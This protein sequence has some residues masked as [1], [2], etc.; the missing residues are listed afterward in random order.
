MK[1]Y[2]LKDDV[3]NDIDFPKGTIISLINEEY[4]HFVV[5]KGKLKGQKG[6]IA[7]GLN[8]WLLENTVENRNLV[9]QFCSE[10]KRLIKELETLSKNWAKIPTVAVPPRRR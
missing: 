8:G 4:Y 5:T 6:G 2:I 9:K 3:Y 10:E 7:D 1:T